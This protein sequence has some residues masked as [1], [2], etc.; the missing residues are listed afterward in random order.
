MRDAIVF[1]D[2]RVVFPTALGLVRA[3]DGIDLALA[4]GRVIALVGESGCGKS[5]L[6]QAILGLLPSYARVSGFIEYGEQDLLSLSPEAI[7]ALRGREI[8][9]IAQDPANSLNPVRKIGPQ[10][11]E[12]FHGKRRDRGRN[13]AEMNRLLGALGF[14][15]PER[16]ARSYPFELSGGMLQ[17]AV[18]AM[19]L[20]NRPRWII[21][22]EPTKGLDAAL[23]FQT[24]ELLERIVT[25]G[26]KGMLV[27]SHDLDLVASFAR[28]IVVMYGGEV[29]ETGPDALRRPMHPYT[30]A[31]IAA[32]PRNGMHPMPGAPR[33]P[34]EEVPGCKFASRCPFREA[35]CACRRPPTIAMQAGYV[36]CFRYA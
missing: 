28:E 32:L 5:V 3:V 11:I 14:E 1:K 18:S 25:Q 31:F 34:G 35:Q 17:R 13:V 24:R 20:A 21:A 22:D 4:P 23:R 19:G 16:V 15:D 27:I 30:Q 8:S 2:L 36:R 6:G 7:R 10:I 33:E 12:S 9:W 26:A 29:M